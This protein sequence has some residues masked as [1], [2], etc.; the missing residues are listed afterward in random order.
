M[1]KLWAGAALFLIAG[2][3]ALTTAQNGPP[4]KGQEP[5]GT[6]VVA[7]QV[8]DA[9]G[10]PVP[11]ARVWLREHIDRRDRYRST[12][13][14]AQGRFRFG[15]VE[16]G[17][18]TIAALAP[19]RSF[20]VVSRALAPGETAI[21]LK[22][23]LQAPQTARIQVAGTDG[24]PVRGAELAYLNVKADRGNWCWFPLEV[25]RREK[26]GVLASNSEGLITVAGVSEGW[27]VRAWVRHADFA[28]EQVVVKAGT[29]PVAVRLP[30]GRALTVEA[31][32][33]ATGKPARAATVIINSNPAA[34][35]F[36]D[37]PVNEDGKFTVRIEAA[38]SLMVRVDHPTLM[39]AKFEQI[40]RWGAEKDDRTVRMLL[41][42]KAKV[43]GRVVE[44]T[45]AAPAPGVWVGLNPGSS[46]VAQARTDN[47]G[48]YGL[49]G[50]EGAAKVQFLSARGYRPDL[51][52]VRRPAAIDVR[53]DPAA[54]AAAADLIVQRVPAI[55]VRG[56]IVLPNGK[57]VAGALVSQVNAFASESAVADAAG[58]FEMQVQR[59]EMHYQSNPD[60]LFLVVCHPTERFSGMATPSL[61]DLQQGT[62]IRIRLEPESEI[63][64]TVVGPDGKPR[65]GVKV[66]LRRELLDQQTPIYGTIDSCITDGQGRYRFQGL[67]RSLQ[68]K[69]TTDDT[70]QKITAP[71]SAWLPLK[72]KTLVVDP[73]TVAAGDAKTSEN[74]TREA[75]ALCCQ[76][77]INSEPLKLSSLRGKV[78]LLDFWAT[79][80]GPCVAELPQVQRVQQLYANNGLVVIGV[81]HNSVPGDRVREFVR[82]K[83]LTFPIALDDAEGGTC[84]AYNVLAQP[85][86]VL[87]GRDGKVQ[88]DMVHGNLLLAV[89]KAVLY[90]DDGD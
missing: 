89:R 29:D 52:P 30:R 65:A 64:G 11:G 88:G 78:V 18:P 84:G 44:D 53:L 38:D 57:P 55:R 41:Y 47:A 58:R 69:V 35:D 83:G 77:W 61:K 85:T 27:T 24:Q 36:Y 54:P 14:D 59:L 33:A 48:R 25:L 8:V 26:I 51:G 46:I 72:R 71:A 9:A 45:T 67:C 62:D 34:I 20:A 31:V 76:G 3:P 63:R 43:H 74:E 70:L 79:W 2:I 39:A 17:Y 80:C 42:R 19:G 16:A 60:D 66:F 87:I 15:E 22:L 28:C 90:S 37:E 75:P 13:A 23:V 21:D 81:H 68:Y 5:A 82:K 6:C 73:L 50:P 56:T 32:E 10:R 1:N 4:A 7:G 40:F 49:E 12:D 86:K